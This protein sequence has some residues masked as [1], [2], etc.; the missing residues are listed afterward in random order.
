MTKALHICL[1]QS[2]DV[3]MAWA[4]GPCDLKELA[5]GGW[6]QKAQPATG[7]QALPEEGSVWCLSMSIASI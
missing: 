2:F 6:V 4:G 1:D 7:Q 3:G 5:A